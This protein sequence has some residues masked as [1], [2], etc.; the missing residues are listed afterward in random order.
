MAKKQCIPGWRKNRPVYTFHEATE[1]WAFVFY[2]RPLNLTREEAGAYLTNYRAAQTDLM[3]SGKVQEK[4]VAGI[5]RKGSD[6][7]GTASRTEIAIERTIAGSDLAALASE[8]GEDGV[9]GFVSEG[10]K[11]S[12]ST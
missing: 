12:I 1:L 2:D 6:Y 9:F 3:Q 7:W 8:K 5:R 10:E 4:T 11:L